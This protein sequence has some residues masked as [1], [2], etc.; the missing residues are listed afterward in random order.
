M[1]KTRTGDR[2]SDNSLVVNAAGASRKDASWL[3]SSGL[4]SV[5]A[6]RPGPG[7]VLFEREER[8]E[9]HGK[10][11]LPSKSDKDRRYKPTTARVI[12]VG[13]PCQD[14]RSGAFVK[15]ELSAGERVVLSRFCGHD[16]EIGG[17]LYVVASE[18]DVA[19]VIGEG[20]VLSEV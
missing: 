14:Q 7:W 20:D 8:P 11:H 19:L 9:A 4:P 12:K 15:P 1:T 18:N 6:F 10:V 13:P 5:E 17:K 3:A 16:I 2:L